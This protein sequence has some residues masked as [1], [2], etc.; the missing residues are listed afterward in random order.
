MQGNGVV[1]QGRYI[2]HQALKAMGGAERITMV[3]SFRPKDP[4]VKD[5]SVLQ[6]V[7]A[8]S[9]LSELYGG[10][11]EYRL[12]MLEERIRRQQKVDRERKKLGR[13]FD[14]ARMKAFLI[15]QQAFIDHMLK[16]LVDEDRVIP[17][18]TDPSH[19]ISEDLKEKAVKKA[20]AYLG[21][22]VSA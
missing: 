16:E 21:E 18:Y 20:K 17:G 4:L 22:R 7:R 1:L 12:E 9:N 11:A 14:T 2:E 6:T 15:E 8:V 5:D 19:L 13:R 10:Y 3:T